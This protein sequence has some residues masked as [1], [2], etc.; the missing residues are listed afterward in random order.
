MIKNKSLTIF[1]V[2]SFTGKPFAGNPAGVCV[3]EEPLDDSLMQ[4]IAAEMNLSETAFAV[5]ITA[6][7]LVD[8]VKFNLRWFTPKCEVN[9]CGHATLATAKVL[10]SI[11][12]LKSELIT[13]S[14]LSGDL[15]AKKVRE[16]HQ[17]DFPAGDIERVELTDYMINAMKLREYGLDDLVQESFRCKRSKK[18]MV[19]FSDQRGVHDIAPNFPELLQAEE[20]FGTRGLIVTAKGDRPYDFISRF[21]AP[22]MGINEDPVT[23]AAHTVL[24]PY[25]SA[26]LG[27][28]RLNAYQASNRGGELIVEMR[29]DPKGHYHRVLITGQAVV[30]MEA[31]LKI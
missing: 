4:N 25:W 12:Q 1:Q 22:S 2:D 29:E 5:K 6:G 31:V 27:K 30:I 15:T 18:L 9:L 14:S 13:F 3:L 26:M 28:K 8:A 7:S 23:G 17:L 10:H 11:Y 20:A 16:M 21:F 19:R 24:T